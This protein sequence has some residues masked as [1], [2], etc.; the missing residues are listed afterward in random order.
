[1]KKL[2]AL[3]IMLSTS[4]LMFAQM[5]FGVGIHG[6]IDVPT[7]TSLTNDIFDSNHY[8]V[9]LLEGV[10]F[11]FSIAAMLIQADLKGFGVELE[12]GYA[13]NELGW[14]YSKKDLEMKGKMTYSS[15]DI[16]LLLG[17]TF[18]KGNFRVT[19]QIGPYISLPIGSL[20]LDVERIV[21]EDELVTNSSI[22]YDWD[23]TS[24]ALF[25]CL[26]GVNIGYKVGRGLINF[27]ARFMS[28]FSHL[29]VNHHDKDGVSVLTRRK[30]TF[31]ISYLFFF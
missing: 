16:P 27:D 4:S 31:G 17:Y 22:A 20:D 21:N 11:D 26:G 10:G 5:K 1:M 29:K 9:A 15:F 18:A 23:I 6:C 12:L 30:T 13:P 2:L 14:E 28:D 19:P 25:G 8:D 24:R 3:I 7:G